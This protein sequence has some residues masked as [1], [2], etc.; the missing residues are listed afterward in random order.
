[1]E[2]RVISFFFFFFSL[3]KRWRGC[4]RDVCV[5]LLI[6]KGKKT[7][8]PWKR[9]PLYLLKCDSEHHIFQVI[10][11]ESA[12]CVEINHEPFVQEWHKYSEKT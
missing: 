1:M 5:G 9:R 10:N 4:S 7:T 8:G 11:W 12:L 3:L 2:G 6:R